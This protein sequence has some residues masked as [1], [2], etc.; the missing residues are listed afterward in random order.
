[1]KE[2]KRA[3]TNG[4]QMSAYLLQAHCF[5][6]LGLERRWRRHSMRRFGTNSLPG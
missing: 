4:N 5:Y 6:L 2:I 3:A 1:M